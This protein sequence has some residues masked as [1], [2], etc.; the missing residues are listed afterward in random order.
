MFEEATCQWIG[1]GFFFYIHLMLNA[2]NFFFQYFIKISV[3]PNPSQIEQLE[4]AY[5]TDHFGLI[6]GIAV[7][8]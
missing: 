4:Y 8:L 1:S 3:R 5:I 6:V 2:K 7:L